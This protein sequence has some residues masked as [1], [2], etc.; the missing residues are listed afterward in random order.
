MKRKIILDNFNRTL[1][2]HIFF[3]YLICT[4]QFVQ[5]DIW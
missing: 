2:Q 4:L 5:L 1:V 3:Y